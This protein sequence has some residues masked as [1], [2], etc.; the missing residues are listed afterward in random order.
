[1]HLWAAATLKV[2][3]AITFYGSGLTSPRWPGMLNGVS[4]ARVLKV[5]WLG[6]Y[7]GRDAGTPPDDLL[8]LRETLTLNATPSTLIVYPDLGHG[9]ALDPRVRRDTSAETKDAFEE[10]WSFLETYLR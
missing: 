2:D 4:A 6:I 9:F 10:V 7:G 3:T 5:P 1:L 8:L